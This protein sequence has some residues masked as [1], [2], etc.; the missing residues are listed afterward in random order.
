MERSERERMERESFAKNISVAE[1]SQLERRTG[2]GPTIE[3]FD[4]KRDL[5][6]DEAFDYEAALRKDMAKRNYR[7]MPNPF[8]ANP[9]HLGVGLASLGMGGGVRGSPVEQRPVG[10]VNRWASRGKLAA[11]SAPVLVAPSV[12]L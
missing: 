2:A 5:S 4:P 8:S 7:Y 1:P 3:A 9:G 6:P 10:V 11:F 12:M